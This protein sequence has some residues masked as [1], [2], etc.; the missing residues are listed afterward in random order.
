MLGI[1][2]KYKESIV[3]KIVFVVIVASFIGTI[4]LVWGRGSKGE[5]GSVAYAAKV[6]GTKVSLEEFD[7][8][9]YRTRGLYEQIY[10]RSLTPEMEKQMNLRKMTLD[11]LIDNVLIRNEAKHMGL[12]VSKDEVAGE[13]AKIPA[14]QK[15]GA[16][17]FNTYQQV[18]KMNRITPKGFEEAEEDDLLVKKARA[19]IQSG[20]TVTD[21][22]ITQQ[23]HKQNDKI[24]LAYVSFGP[25]DV[26]SGIKLTDAD[27]DSYLQGHQAEFRT[28]EQVSVAFVRVSPEQFASKISVTPEEAQTY[29]QKNIDRYQAKGGILPFDQVKEQATADALKQ[30]EA[31][32]AYEKAADA[33]NKFKANGDIDA[34]ANA[35][36]AKV[37]KTGIFTADAAPAALAGEKDVIARS[38]ATKQG[39][40]GGPVETAKGIYLV[41]VTERKPAAV[42]PL[43]QIRSKVEEKALAAKAIEVAQKKAQDTLAQLAKGNVAGMKETGNFGYDPT[44]KV[45]TIGTSPELME[46]A[47]ALTTASPA[48]KQAVKV[49]E[50]W[51]AVKLKSRIEAPTTDL[52][53]KK[54]EIKK[55]LLPKKQQEAVD[56]W[57]K[58]LR[59]KAKIDINPSILANQNQ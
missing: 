31:K 25:A 28:P 12:S 39:E 30:K 33:A 19:K 1:M 7:K 47:F 49:G 3:I 42:P 41:K 17:D 51:Y 10:G 8:A 54:D 14:F 11:N 52:A 58:G 37:E 23:F 40:I 50:R 27:L 59:A 21:Q 6:D 43:A 45:P 18:L 34:A 2:R 4:F 29:Y 20:V 44:G 55:T 5:S 48:A 46:Q 13:I 22:E 9:Y 16:F 26:K 35:L 32:E 53:A 15:D 24:D 38:F 57:L 36:G 56:T